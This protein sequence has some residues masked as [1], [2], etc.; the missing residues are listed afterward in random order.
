LGE[1]LQ[2]HGHL[3]IFTSLNHTIKQNINKWYLLS[4]KELQ[5][6]TLSDHHPMKVD[7]LR[8]LCGSENKDLFDFRRSLREALEA[9]ALATGWSWRIDEND[10]VHITKSPTPS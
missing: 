10:L 9:L 7:I 3:S 1:Y 8:R 4:K 5:P 6:P 2:I